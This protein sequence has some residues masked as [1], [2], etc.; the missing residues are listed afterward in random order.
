M[1]QCRTSRERLST[2]CYTVARYDD[3]HNEKKKDL[4]TLFSLLAMVVHGR[5]HGCKNR[6]SDWDTMPSHMHHFVTKMKGIDF[7]ELFIAL[8]HLPDFF[9]FFNKGCRVST[10]IY[11]SKQVR[12]S[13][14]L[15]QIHTMYKVDDCSSEHFFL[16]N[17]A[18]DQSKP[19]Q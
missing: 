6:V 18:Q 12:V 19:G 5:C 14:S 16:R 4:Q 17:F 11:C 9:F 7:S 15:K 10:F 13:A 8:H 2:L 1:C 3:D